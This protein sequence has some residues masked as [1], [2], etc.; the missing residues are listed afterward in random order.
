MLRDQVCEL[1]F[2]DS[3]LT[4]MDE[5]AMVKILCDRQTSDPTYSP[6]KEMEDTKPFGL[7][8]LS[9]HRQRFSPLGDIQ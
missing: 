8:S 1:S 3:P 9:Q 7:V 2:S 5:V 4:E 6:F